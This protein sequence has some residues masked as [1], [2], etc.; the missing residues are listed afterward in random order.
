MHLQIVSIDIHANIPQAQI[1]EDH[2]ASVKSKTYI[3]CELLL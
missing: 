2:R 1:F 3:L